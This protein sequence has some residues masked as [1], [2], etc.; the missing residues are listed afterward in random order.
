MS[1]QEE[2]GQSWT[3]TRLYVQGNTQGVKWTQRL[4]GL[5]HPDG[6]LLKS[7]VYQVGKSNEKRL[8]VYL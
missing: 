4:V 3:R 6:I 2:L 1:I 5:S 8:W 7:R